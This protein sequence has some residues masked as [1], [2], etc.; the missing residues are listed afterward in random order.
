MEAFWIGYSLIIGLVLAMADVAAIEIAHKFGRRPGLAVWGVAVLVP[1]AVMF[2]LS[3]KVALGSAVIGALVT[4]A[5][6]W[7]KEQEEKERLGV[8]TSW[9]LRFF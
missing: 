7:F 2:Y 6:I 9:M 1:L 8:S 4:S 3:P 5:A